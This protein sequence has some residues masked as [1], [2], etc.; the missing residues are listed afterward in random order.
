[1]IF[2]QQYHHSSLQ[3]VS[4]LGCFPPLQIIEDHKRSPYRYPSSGED[5]R[6]ILI[7]TIWSYLPKFTNFCSFYIFLHNWFPL[8]YIY[9]LPWAKNLAGPMGICPNAHRTS[10]PLANIRDGTG[11][12]WCARLRCFMQHKEISNLSHQPNKSHQKISAKYLDK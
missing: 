10:L 8:P 2:L 4:F 5:G 7:Q 12:Y 3:K 1:M 6:K 11:Y 9:H